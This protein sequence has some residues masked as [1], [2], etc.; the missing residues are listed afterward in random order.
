[1]SS[2]FA[3]RRIVVEPFKDLPPRSARQT[4]DRAELLMNGPPSA[5]ALL[6]ALNAET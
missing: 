3:L 1:M 6:K 2:V 5:Q 4:R